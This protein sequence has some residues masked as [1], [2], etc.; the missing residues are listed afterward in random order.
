MDRFL[1]KGIRVSKGFTQSI[2]A[3]NIGMTTATYCR[4]EMGKRD[5]TT[6]EVRKLS[7]FLDLNFQQV[8]AIFFNQKLTDG[9]S[10]T[11]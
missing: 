7:I 8:N 1:L 3:K 4:K 9:K 11:G 10:K 6:D 2:V 5:F